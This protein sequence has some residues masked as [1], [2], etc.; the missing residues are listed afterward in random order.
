[1]RMVGNGEGARGGDRRS[2]EVPSKEGGIVEGRGRDG[3]AW[4]PAGGMDLEESERRRE[5][6]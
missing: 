2:A 3:V 4:V 6:T 1:M 5:K